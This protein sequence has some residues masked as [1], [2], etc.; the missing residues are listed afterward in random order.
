VSQWLPKA[1]Q[2]GGQSSALFGAAS[3]RH[4]QEK[5]ARFCLGSSDAHAPAERSVPLEAKLDNIDNFRPVARRGRPARGQMIGVR[6]NLKRQADKIV[7][8]NWRLAT[9]TACHTHR[10]SLQIAKTHRLRMSTKVS[11]SFGHR[12]MRYVSALRKSAEGSGAQGGE[13]GV[14]IESRVFGT[15]RRTEANV[16]GGGSGESGAPCSH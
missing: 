14:F 16:D 10:C 12:S 1:E 13:L 3:Q 6:E 15:A 8:G 5:T 2:S 4:K 9:H 7:S 11:D